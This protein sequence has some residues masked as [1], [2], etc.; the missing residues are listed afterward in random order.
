MGAGAFSSAGGIGDAATRNDAD[1]FVV[2]TVTRTA[3]GSGADAYVQHN[4]LAVARF[5][6]TATELRLEFRS[7]TGTGHGLAVYV[8]GAWNQTVA[9]Y[10]VDSKGRAK[11]ISLPAG[12]KTVEIYDSVGLQS[13]SPNPG[14][15]LQAICG[16]D[17]R[18]AALPTSG[19]G[20][21]TRRLA[22][23]GDSIMAG[24]K[25]TFQG[26]EGLWPLVR[27]DYPGRVTVEAYSGRQLNGEADLT[28]LGNLLA[29]MVAGATTQEVWIAIGVNDYGA[30]VPKATFQTKYGQ[31]L[32]AIHAAAPL[33]RIWCQTLII[34][35]V[36]GANGNG[37]TM[38]DFRTAIS[39]A[40][41]TRSAYATLVNG[42]TALALTDLDAD[43]TH[44]ITGVAGPPATGFV[45]YKAFVKST[46]GY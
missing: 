10:A 24:Y 14:T 1:Q 43:G 5:K 44:P 20:S 18:A 22:V 7:D 26:K 42:F 39:N 3:L 37:D 19:V 17:I 40:Q 35:N 27:Q 30:N 6:T 2:D 41:S 34:N 8:D 15:W 16:P 46:I 32:D 29:A 36:E 11:V 12:L 38:P 23:Y 33:A 28:V 13:G 45:K 31:L 25:A 9:P 4:C 21:S